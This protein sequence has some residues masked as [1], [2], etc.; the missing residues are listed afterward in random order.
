MPKFLDGHLLIATPAISDPR[1]MKSVIFLC[2]HDSNH[3]MGLVVNKIHEELNLEMLCE[4]IS[5]KTPRL[6][7]NSIILNGGP[8]EVSRGFVLHSNDHILP[9]SKVISNDFAITCS[10]DLIKEIA[11]GKGPVKYIITLGYASWNSG[12]LESELKQ[13][14]WLTMPAD[15]EIV[16]YSEIEKKWSKALG[17]LGVSPNQITDQFGYA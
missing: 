9:D 4:S 15:P 16:F 1:F 5:F 10:T 11:L 14:S 12:Q 8:M 7:N 2:S 6:T 17:V 13:N 3:A